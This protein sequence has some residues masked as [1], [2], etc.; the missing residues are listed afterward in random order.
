MALSVVR[1]SHYE[2]PTRTQRPAEER[3]THAL[4]SNSYQGP[5]FLSEIADKNTTMV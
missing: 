1:C 2:S 5:S 4:I 3:L